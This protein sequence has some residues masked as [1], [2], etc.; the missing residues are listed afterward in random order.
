MNTHLIEKTIELRI[1][2]VKKRV[3]SVEHYNSDEHTFH[4]GWTQ[5]YWEGQLSVLEDL[6][7]LVMDLR[8]E[9]QLMREQQDKWNQKLINSMYA[10][11]GTDE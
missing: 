4:G 2:R 1:N 6:H 11:G 10:T 8:E 3:Q 7:D 5:G 9:D